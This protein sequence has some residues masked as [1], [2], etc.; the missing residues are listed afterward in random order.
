MKYL[1][2]PMVKPK[3][4]AKLNPK[5]AGLATTMLPVAMDPKPKRF[6]IS[7]NALEALSK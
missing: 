3:S 7:T 2:N 1:K 6:M 4:N 5:G